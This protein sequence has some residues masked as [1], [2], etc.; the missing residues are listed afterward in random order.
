MQ[1]ELSVSSEIRPDPSCEKPQG[2]RIRVCHAQAARRLRTLGPVQDRSGDPKRI[3]DEQRN[4][5]P[6]L[7]SDIGDLCT[8]PSVRVPRN[9]LARASPG[10]NRK[11]LLLAQPD[12]AT[13]GG[14]R[15][16][17]DR[18]EVHDL[19]VRQPETA[20][21]LSQLRSLPSRQSVPP[22]D[23]GPKLAPQVHGS[24]IW[25]R[26]DRNRDAS[27]LT[28]S[29]AVAQ[30]GSALALGARGRRFESDQPDR[31]FTMTCPRV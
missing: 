12:I 1:R 18:D 24:T 29:R 8:T 14:Q 10:P 11:V 27:T 22:L 30:L 7:L 23:P 21:V 16:L 26:W 19:A 31:G 20:K 17:L 25:V 4:L 5:L 28:R 9:S 13:P 6:G 15:G 2:A 3:I